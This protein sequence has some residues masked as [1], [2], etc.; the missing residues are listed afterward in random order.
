MS[1]D[2]LPAKM[3]RNSKAPGSTSADLP[4]E[5]EEAL[6]LEFAKRHGKDL[7]YVEDWKRW[8]CWDGRHWCEDRTRLV[9]DLVRA[10]CRE[11]AS[12]AKRKTAISVARA[13]TVSGVERLARADRRLAAKPEEFDAS[14]LL[15]NTRGGTVD[16]V[17]GRL[18]PHKRKDYLTKITAVS[19]AG[20]C[21]TWLRFLDRITGGDHELQSYLQTMLGYGLTGLT[22]ASVF[23]FLYG[24]GANGKSVLLATVTEILGEYATTAPIEMFLESRVDRHP[25]E[26]AMLRGSRLVC[27]TEIEEGK[28]W[29]EALIKRLTGGE[30]VTA[31]L[32][33][34]DFSAFTP[35]LK[36]ILT[37]NHRPA[38]RTVDES[39]RRR[40]HL[41]PFVV[42]IPEAERDPNLLEKLRAEASGILAWMIEGAVRFLKSGLAPSEAV[43]TAT[44]EYLAAEDLMRRWLDECCIADVNATTMT[45]DLFKSWS[46]WCQGSS[47]YPGNERRFV[48]RL[49]ERG[50]ARDKDP[51]FRRSIFRG[52]ALTPKATTST[53]E[54]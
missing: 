13:S 50:Y 11:V 15:L 5:A 48:Q 18:R 26:L 32:M 29:N 49:E 31:R 54:P 17:T 24:T 53:V 42:T 2:T 1:K 6:A 35:T 44:A 19:P 33:R 36:L 21:P 20:E 39:I 7:R 22:N 12:G 25:T 52:I 34:Q 38:L 43:A 37:G 10:L 16:L 40:V 23:F 47:E 30:K 41:V 45:T 3:I 28:R 51:Q 46:A 4:S 14:P 27:A 8:L 9:I